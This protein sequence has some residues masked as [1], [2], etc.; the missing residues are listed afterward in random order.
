MS[1]AISVTTTCN[2]RDVLMQIADTL[3]E[4]KL[5]ACCQIGGPITSIYRWQGKIE[6]SV[7]WFCHIKTVSE[8]LEAV[9]TEIRKQHTYEEPEIIAVEIAGGSAG[10]LD[11]LA[12]QTREE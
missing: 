2:Q 6:D 1:R 7:E 9:I 5:A 3:V 10:Y 12:K 4:K 8:R 11:W